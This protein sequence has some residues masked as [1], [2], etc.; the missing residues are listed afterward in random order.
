M[1]PL[2]HPDK[3]EAPRSLI[4]VSIRLVQRCARA[5]RRTRA[6]VQKPFQ[7]RGEVLKGGVKI[8]L[9]PLFLPSS[10]APQRRFAVILTS[11]QP[12]RTPRLRST[13]TP[14]SQIP[15]ATWHMGSWFVYFPCL[16]ISLTSHQPHR[17]PRLRSTHTH[18]QIPDPHCHMAHGLLAPGTWALGTWH[19]GTWRWIGHGQINSPASRITELAKSAVPQRSK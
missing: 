15:I 8:P 6:T 7:R 12:H 11:H 9:A 13:P 5:R 17:T 16:F 14:R 18:T 4:A 2:R 10:A 19:M 1:S 3:T